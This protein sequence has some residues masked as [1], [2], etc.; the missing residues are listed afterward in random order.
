MDGRDL[1][2]WDVLDCLPRYVSR[3]LDWKQSIWDLKWHSII[4]SGHSKWQ[5]NA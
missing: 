1:N 5:L 2:I 3:E 4:G